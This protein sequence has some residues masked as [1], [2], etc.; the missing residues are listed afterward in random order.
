MRS[1][2][3]TESLEEEKQEDRFKI[4]V[5]EGNVFDVAENST[6]VQCVS[7][8]CGNKKG[9]VVQFDKRFPDAMKKLKSYLDENMI[10]SPTA[11]ILTYQGEGLINL[12]TKDTVW[13]IP[14]YED[15]R[16]SISKMV[17]IC[18]DYNITKLVMPKIGC[19]LDKLEWDK[20]QEILT[21]EF[22]QSGLEMEIQVRYLPE[23]NMGTGKKES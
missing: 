19:G 23:N 18:R 21:E 13:N 16:K 15:L 17:E 20:V 1:V 10:S 4:E 2:E 9:I 12:V 6:Y 5:K 8:C 11:A 14:T 3:F 22:I 7:R